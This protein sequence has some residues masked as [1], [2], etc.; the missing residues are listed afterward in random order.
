MEKEKV[1][2]NGITFVGV[3][4]GCAHAGFTEKRLHF[5]DAVENV[6]RIEQK[7]EHLCCV[8]DLL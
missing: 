5:F 1:K 2:P 3:L 6:Y 4:N 8:V 7:V